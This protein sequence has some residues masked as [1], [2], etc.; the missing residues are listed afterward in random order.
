[1]RDRAAGLA[2]AGAACHARCGRRNSKWTR[3]GHGSYDEIEERDFFQHA[4]RSSRIVLHFCRPQTERCALLDKHLHAL[5][6]RHCETRFVKLNAEKAPFL[7]ARLKIKMLPTLVLF[8]VLPLF[9]FLAMH[10][11]NSSFWAS[12]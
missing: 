10:F 5:A 1:V 4:H 2:G 9:A 7:A 3:Q 6:E 11:R 8:K 12:S